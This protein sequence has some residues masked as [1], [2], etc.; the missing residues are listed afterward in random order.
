M[1]V[2]LATSSVVGFLVGAIAYFL[3]GEEHM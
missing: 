3:T 1:I 2:N